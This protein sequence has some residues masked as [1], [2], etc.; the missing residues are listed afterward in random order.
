MSWPTARRLYLKVPDTA[1]ARHE[2]EISVFGP[3]IGECIVAH[4]GDGAWIVIDSCLDRQTG[5]AV[6]LDY[7]RSLHVDLA[8]QIKL[9]VAT[10]WHDDHVGGMAEILNAAESAKFVDSAAYAFNE[11]VKIV[12]LD[13]RMAP[14]FAVTKEYRGII[15]MLEQR[16]AK[17][18]KREAVGP[19]RALANRRLLALSDAERSLNAEVF[20]LSP[21]D[22]VLNHAQAELR[23]ALS[24]V[25][26]GRR[27]P[28]QGPNQLC[29]VLWLR[30][31]VLSTLLGADLEHV[32][33]ATQGWQAIVHSTE[34]PEGRAG[35][36]KVPHHGSENADCPSCWTGLLSDQPI[37]IGTPY[38]PSRL[39]RPADLS[40]LC[41]RTTQVFFTSDSVHYP[42]PKRD[43]AVE[44]TLREI[45]V[46]RRALTGRMGHVR[47][48]CDARDLNQLELIQLYNGAHRVRA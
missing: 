29:V 28:R 34:R 9:V 15:K 23:S 47:V 37:A 45:A 1:P 41:T 33:G 44:R 21:G 5:N 12:A 30:V 8:S 39:P 3:G 19:I 25:E 32:S 27:P 43:K 14:Q 38:S 11:L 40:R 16:R 26:H 46:K 10:H 36:F 20:A 35:I 4:V 31:G 18:E 22:G 2:L 13:G 42:R 24:S 6:A 7:L 48:R 17:G